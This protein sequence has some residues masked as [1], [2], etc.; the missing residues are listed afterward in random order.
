MTP[1]PE[2]GTLDE[3]TKL[4]LSYCT[5]LTT[6]R[7]EIGRLQGLTEFNRSGCSSL[8]TMPPEIGNLDELTKL[9]LSQFQYEIPSGGVVKLVQR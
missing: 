9:Y 6:L 1:P 3:F 8:T 7:P 4:N 2:I 5:S